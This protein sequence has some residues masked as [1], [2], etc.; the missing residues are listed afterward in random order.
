MGDLG[1]I[2]MDETELLLSN[3]HYSSIKSC[4][5]NDK[6]KVFVL[7]TIS[8]L[9]YN[10]T[11]SKVFRIGLLFLNI[12]LTLLLTEYEISLVVGWGALVMVM[13]QNIVCSIDRDCYG[14]DEAFK[15][16]L[17]G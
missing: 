10:L 12:I 4:S 13:T 9:I 5:R 16:L 2:P 14:I 17:N 6:F 8:I 15:I 3:S 11:V 7:C 1:N